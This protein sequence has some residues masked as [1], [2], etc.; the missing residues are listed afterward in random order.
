MPWQI[1]TAGLALMSGLVVTSTDAPQQAR[2][3]VVD[4]VSQPYQRMTVPRL[5]G[6]ASVRRRA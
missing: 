5:V 6:R 2:V 4:V 3:E 1:L